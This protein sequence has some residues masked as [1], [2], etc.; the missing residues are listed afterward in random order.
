MLSMLYDVTLFQNLLLPS[1]VIDHVT[2]PSL[3]DWRDS[4]TDEP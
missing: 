3:C 4:M 1:L 2:M